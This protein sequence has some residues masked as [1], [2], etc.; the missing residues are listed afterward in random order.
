MAGVL[1]PGVHARL[2]DMLHRGTQQHNLASRAQQSS[3]DDG[4]GKHVSRARHH[5]MAKHPQ[6]ST[7]AVRKAVVV[8]H[9]MP[10]VRGIGAH[11]CY[12]TR[13]YMSAVWNQPDVSYHT[14]AK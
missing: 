2:Q 11:R 4:D 10:K 7:T 8:C 13:S 6:G 14:C 5:A 3:F 9:N 1:D 12:N